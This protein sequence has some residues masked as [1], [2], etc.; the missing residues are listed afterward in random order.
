MLHR[1]VALKVVAQRAGAEKSTRELLLHEARSTSALSHP[2]I[3]AVREVGEFAGELYIVME[4]VE[5]NPL[6]EL[7]G[8]VGLPVE[9]VLRDGVQI[10]A[11]PMPTTATSCIAT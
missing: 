9:S 6:A 4:L 7:I 5:G 3:C 8:S 11:A 1:D 10:A 2:N